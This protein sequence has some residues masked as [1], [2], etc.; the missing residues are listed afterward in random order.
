MHGQENTRKTSLWSPASQPHVW[1]PTAMSL[2]ASSLALRS[3]ILAG[4][5]QG[6]IDGVL[7]RAG[8]R[9][10]TAR[11]KQLS[12][13]GLLSPPSAEVAQRITLS[14][15]SFRSKEYDLLCLLYPSLLRGLSVIW[16]I[17]R[18]RSVVAERVEC[19]STF[20]V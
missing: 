3:K 18:A 1:Q 8:W 14:T 11:T 19:F 15:N 12:D 2:A 9:T 13:L 7:G 4:G 16:S 10:R 5:F 6:V 20:L 17:H